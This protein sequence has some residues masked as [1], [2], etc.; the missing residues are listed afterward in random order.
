M[1][2]L[3]LSVVAAL[4]ALTAG[5]IAVLLYRRKRTL[6]RY[7]EDFNDELLATAGD[8]SVGR[9]LADYKNS[10]LADTA[11]TANRLFDALA[12]R[13]EEIQDR[14]RLFAE[15][16]RTIPE[17]VLIHDERILLANDSAASLV[18]LSRE[19]LQGREAADLVKP[20]YRAL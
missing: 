17:V 3:V 18:G 7:L 10:P 14:D 13:D 9:R 8:A 20:A 16:A 1:A 4:L 19:Q 11:A 5:G 12:E 2:S 15:F 6:E